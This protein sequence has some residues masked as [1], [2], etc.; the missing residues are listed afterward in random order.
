M[1]KQDKADQSAA[2]DELLKNMDLQEG[3]SVDDEGAENY[4]A[5]LAVILEEETS[6]PRMNVNILVGLFVVVLSINLLKGGGAFPSPLGIQCGS[7]AFWIANSIMLVW[8]IA[9]TVYVRSY[10]VE[11]FETKKRVGYKY[12]EGDIQWN[13]RATIV[14]PSVC[15]LAGFFAGMFGVGGGIVKGPLMLAMGVHPA[16]ASASSATMILFTSFTATTS[17]FVFGLLDREYAPVCFTIGLVATYFGQIGL[18]MLMKRA[19]RNSYIAFSIGGVARISVNAH[20]GWQNLTS[21]RKA[22]LSTMNAS[23][24]FILLSCGS[25]CVSGSHVRRREI[26]FF[27]DPPPTPSPTP[28]CSYEQ[29]ESL[30]SKCDCRWKSKDK[31]WK[32]ENEYIGCLVSATKFSPCELQAAVDASNCLP[33]PWSSHPTE[34]PSSEPT[35]S[36]MPTTSLPSATPSS[37]PSELPSSEPTMSSMPTTSLPSE[38]PS[39][40]PSEVPSSEPTTSS[41]PTTSLPSAAPSISNSPSDSPSLS[42]LPTASPTINPTQNP[43]GLP[44]QY[45]SHSPSMAPSTDAVKQAKQKRLV[46]FFEIPENDDFFRIIGASPTPAPGPPVNHG[47]LEVVGNDG[48]PRGVFPLSAC[49]GDCDSDRECKGRL[50]CMNR[51]RYE[52]VPG[53]T[54][55]G[56]RGKDYC[57]DPFPSRP[58]S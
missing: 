4:S 57:V 58:W 6:T 39:S 25:I 29:I 45:P 1:E 44:T 26:G 50:Q 51:D 11:R 27:H 35:T 47:H 12:K 30:N 48:L 41:M 8:I 3:S 49:Q 55:S 23:I 33:F 36:N 56:Q 18:S 7:T 21:S 2:G 13:E 40:L 43:T 17:F 32:N 20:P 37:L 24:W 31:E 52:P 46:D 38:I 14:Y 34:L 10:L 28:R 54:G 16:V 15:C 5:E 9:I 19:Q 22:T 53:C 42:A